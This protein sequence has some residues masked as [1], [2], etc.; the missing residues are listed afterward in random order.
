MYNIHGGQISDS[1]SN[2]SY[3]NFCKQI[4]EGLVEGFS[5]TEVIRTVLR[6]IKPGTFKDMLT[7]KD[8]LTV[9]ELNVC[10]LLLS[11]VRVSNMIAN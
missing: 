4:D 3:N 11:K 10:Y 6:V 5:E 9:A 7:T 1:D 2:L 8:S